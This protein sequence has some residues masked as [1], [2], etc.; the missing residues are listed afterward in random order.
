MLAGVEGR[1]NCAQKKNPKVFLHPP[2]TKYLIL[3]EASVISLDFLRIRGI[4]NRV[5]FFVRWV[6]K[7][8]LRIFF[9]V[10]MSMSMK[11]STWKN[12]PTILIGS[13]NRK[14][15]FYNRVSFSS[16]RFE[17]LSPKIIWTWPSH[18]PEGETRLIQFSNF[19]QWLF[20]TTGSNLEGHEWDLHLEIGKLPKFWLKKI[21]RHRNVCVTT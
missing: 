16:E 5:I 2:A 1:H 4:W 10:L 9:S 14:T 7:I 12:G 6:G 21:S 11:G 17:D 13:V 20:R 8:R 3:L 18:L 19:L 15:H